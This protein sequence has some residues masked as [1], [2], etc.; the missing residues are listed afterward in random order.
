MAAPVGHPLITLEQHD[1][2]EASSDSIRDSSGDTKQETAN[3][4]HPPFSNEPSEAE[5]GTETVSV[6][7]EEQAD[8]SS[9]ESKESVPGGMAA[10]CVVSAD[11]VELARAFEGATL[12]GLTS[13]GAPHAMGTR[14]Q[15]QIDTTP[16]M[17]Y[18]DESHCHPNE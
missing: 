12:C 6:A 11:N 16:N 2:Y 17:S 3:V 9:Q 7:V 18:R 15:H 4:L 13:W 5:F 14:C 1:A 8:S 10:E